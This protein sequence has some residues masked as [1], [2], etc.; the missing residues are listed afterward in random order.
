MREAFKLAVMDA[1]GE[2]FR[3]LSKGEYITHVR[4]IF[5]RPIIVEAF[6][7]Y[8]YTAHNPRTIPYLRRLAKAVTGD[9]KYKCQHIIPF[10]Y[11]VP[12]GKGS[13]SKKQWVWGWPNDDQGKAAMQEYDAKS[14]GIVKGQT[15]KAGHI[16]QPIVTVLTKDAVEK[17]LEKEVEEE[18][19]ATAEREKQAVPA[20]ASWK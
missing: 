17:A 19:E 18:A 9:P 8:E 4:L 14:A 12:I 15:D 7:R 3:Q 20:E 2:Q 10:R 1:I 6:F 11:P 16:E 5:G 13:R